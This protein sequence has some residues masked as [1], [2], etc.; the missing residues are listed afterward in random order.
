MFGAEVNF[1]NEPLN[2]QPDAVITDDLRRMDKLKYN[3]S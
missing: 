2:F 1:L 3:E